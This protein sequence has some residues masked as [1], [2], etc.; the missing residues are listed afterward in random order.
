MD[1]IDP[2]TIRLEVDTAAAAESVKEFV[3]TTQ[4]ALDKGLT[5]AV[6]RAKRKLEELAR[7]Q[8]VVNGILDQEKQKIEELQKK[9]ETAGASEK[10]EID[11]QLAGLQKI[12]ENRKIEMVEIEKKRAKLE[13]ITALSVAG[14]EQEKAA[15]RKATD[16]RLT[17][18]GVLRD[19]AKAHNNVS[20]EME[21][22]ITIGRNFLSV[23]GG[24]AIWN[25]VLGTCNQLLSKMREDMEGI[26]SAG[27]KLRGL[28]GS[29]FEQERTFFAEAGLRTA[30]EQEQGRAFINE[31]QK[32]QGVER[33]NVIAAASTLA[34]VF[35][36]TG[37]QY[38]S[39]QGK[40]LVGNA[41]R[42]VDQGVEGQGL[43]DLALEELHK[44][45]QLTG[46]QFNQRASNLLQTV[47][48]SPSRLNLLLQSYQQ[49]R[50]KYETAGF[51]LD[52]ASKMVGKLA[53][54]TSPGEV[55]EMVGGFFRGVDR[56]MGLSPKEVAELHRKIS[57][58]GPIQTDILND[59]LP[60][61]TPEKQIALQ[62][63]MRKKDTAIPELDKVFE[64]AAK[65]GGKIDIKAATEIM[66]RL[67]PQQI[68][69][70]GRDAV[71]PRNMV[72]IQRAVGFENM[73]TA[74]NAAPM[75]AP[76]AP[77]VAVEVAKEEA[78]A[79]ARKQNPPEPY[80]AGFQKMAENE[81]AFIEH[82]PEQKQW[83][84][85]GIGYTVSHVPSFGTAGFFT[86]NTKEQAAARVYE[87][88][89]ISIARK[90]SDIRSGK[91]KATPE[92][93]AALEQSASDI[94]D[95]LGMGRWGT[96]RQDKWSALT[97]A[98]G[99]AF[100][101]LGELSDGP[102]AD[103]LLKEIDE[104]GEETWITENQQLG[105]SPA[106][107]TD[108]RKGGRLLKQSEDALKGVSSPP[109][110]PATPPAS[111]PPAPTPPAPV[112]TVPPAAPATQPAKPVSIN[113][114]I[115]NT[116]YGGTYDSIGGPLETEN[117][118]G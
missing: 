64:D 75:P 99:K 32:S 16:E 69:R 112:P 52:D 66:G 63:K 39:E 85:H 102:N 47:G 107:V 27:E 31:I 111:T 18:L 33:K 70:I 84:S 23:M 3:A 86:A 38:D 80:E 12:V 76:Q 37:I 62:E 21:G 2:I 46:D 78:D 92:Q 74:A 34:P 10:K 14:S 7:Q 67:N 30:P 61:L 97:R 68:A 9:R 44:N 11:Q 91:A 114:H 59:Q 36:Q 6:D 54:N 110:A 13:E 116:V 103:D 60:L 49:N 94:K 89:L 93:T 41:A 113:Y 108:T 48:G 98:N 90:L 105:E 42:F 117:R 45:P 95:A 19:T 58:F 56:L 8:Q 43:A 104:K 106:T 55:P 88:R 100:N 73:P 15:I 22:G 87:K 118:Y 71:G 82:N 29:R 109:A 51:T 1:G 50:G 4:E 57:D 79:I 17:Q 72:A 101:G 25:G 40:G 65:N 96:D 28:A 24:W 77:E 20:E 115:R 26:A 83:I 5:T 35:K 81:E 53:Q